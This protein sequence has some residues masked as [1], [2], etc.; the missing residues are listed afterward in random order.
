[1]FVDVY[2][3][4]QSKCRLV[5]VYPRWRFFAVVLLLG[6]NIEVVASSVELVLCP[7]FLG[8]ARKS[9]WLFFFGE[10]VGEAPQSDGTACDAYMI[11]GFLSACLSLAAPLQ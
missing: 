8:E 1:M 10:A 4:T 3:Y 6:K 9:G 2:V 5:A 7:L 11:H